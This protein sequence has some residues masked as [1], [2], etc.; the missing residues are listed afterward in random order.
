MK[1]II[2]APL[3]YVYISFKTVLGLQSELQAV[4][5]V[6]QNN[7][8]YNSRTKPGE[9]R[10]PCDSRKWQQHYGLLSGHLGHHT[11]LSL[12]CLLL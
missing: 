7:N 10:C 3:T 11:A 12:T 2:T 6:F 8:S 5:N 9:L 1:I 4:A